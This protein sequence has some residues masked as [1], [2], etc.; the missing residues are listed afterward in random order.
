MLFNLFKGKDKVEKK[1]KSTVNEKKHDDKRRQSNESDRKRNNNQRVATRK[2]EIGEHKID[3]QLSQLPKEYKYL[4]DIMIENPKS[5]SGYSQIDHLVITPYGIFVIETKNYQGTIYGGKNRKTWLVN[6]KFKMLSPIVQN[7]GHI[8]ALKKYVDEQYHNKFFSIVSFTKRCTL[9]IDS[10]LRDIHSDELVI[11]DLY[12]SESIQRK[13]S[14]NKLKFKEALLTEQDQSAVYKE[15]TEANITDPKIREMHTTR[16]NEKK[17][18][19]RTKTQKSDSKCEVCRKAVSNK[20]ATYCLSNKK[21][22]GKIYC[23]EH[24]KTS[25]K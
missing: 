15:F 14:I 24:Q 11:Y 20:V 5:I 21:F 8:E 1:K 22:N 10:E 23:Y 16:I 13:V 12:L 17:N 2:G 18:T 6:G 25:V 19:E 9:K 3:I 7:Y 4:N